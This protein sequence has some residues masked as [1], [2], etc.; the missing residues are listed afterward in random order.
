MEKTLRIN[1]IMKN[2]VFTTPY[3]RSPEGG[4]ITILCNKCSMRFYV[5]PPSPFGY[6]A[7]R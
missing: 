2:A 5:L 7:S 1:S 6:A 3:V 4:S